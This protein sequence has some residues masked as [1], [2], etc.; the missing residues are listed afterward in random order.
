MVSEPLV[1]AEELKERF[2][3]DTVTYEEAKDLDAVVLINAHDAFKTIELA[4]LRSKMR[5]PVLVDMKNFFPRQ[6]AE[7]L[8][9]RYVSL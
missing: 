8:G 5:T 4:D 6:Q 7:E 2:G 1:T 3:L 9:F